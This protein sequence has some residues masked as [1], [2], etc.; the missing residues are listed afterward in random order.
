MSITSTFMR[1]V[2]V[3][4]LFATGAFL[5]GCDG[6]DGMDGAAGPAGPTG[7]TGPAGPAGPGT[8]PIEGA[9]AQAKLE[10]CGTCH[11]GAG[12]YHQAAYDGYN[13]ASDLTLA[14]EDVVSAPGAA[15]G[16]FDITMTVYVE[17]GG[18]PY[19]GGLAALPQKRF[20]IQGT[21]GTVF[22]GSLN[23]GLTTL[24]AGALPGQYTAT[25]NANFDPL[26][27]G[28]FF[29][30]GYVA[31]EPLHT[32]GMQLYDNVANAGRVFGAIPAYDSPAN[33]E[34]CEKCHGTPYMKHGYRAAEVAGLPDFLACKACHYDGRNGG[35]QDWQYMYDMPY[36]WATDQAPTADYSYE[37]IVMN[38]VHMSHG[39]EFPYPAPLVNCAT[40]HEG[41]LDMIVAE[42]NFT[43]AVCKGCHVETGDWGENDKYEQPN[44]APSMRQLWTDAGVTFHDYAMD[45][46]VC[47]TTA[48]NVAPVLADY[49]TGYDARIYNAAGEKLADLNTVAISSVSLTGT[50]LDVR[51]TA[52]NTAIVPMLGVNF[53]GWDTNDFLV[54][55]HSRDA[56]GLRMEKTIGTANALFTEEADSVAG[57]WHVTIDLANY[58]PVGIPTIP[59]LIAAGQVKTAEI[60]IMP[61]LSI[62]GVAVALDAVTK[63]FDVGTNT[64]AA[65]TTAGA[66]D[67]AKC[68]AC[69]EQLAVTFHGGS[70]RGGS[71]VACRTCHVGTSG[72]SHLEMQSRDI[73]S[74]AHAIHAFQA[75]DTDEVDFTDPVELERYKIHVEHVFPNFTILNCEGCHKPGTF[76]VPDQSK[77]MPALLSAAYEWNVDRNIG[78]VPEYVTGPASMSC[79]GC[80]RAYPI[81]E[82]EPGELATFNAHTQQMGT[83]VENDENDEVLYGIIFKIMEIFE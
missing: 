63:S 69:H 40:C 78:A 52:N 68:N 16:T 77:T 60:A 26:A 20:Y 83:L 34:G 46:Q 70:G 13:D 23:K 76:N 11:A 57:N 66:V 81:N 1:S 48:A 30:Y 6:D 75:F 27:L 31:D 54:S 7:P 5:G 28:G 19:T 32:E 38:D 17:K 29:G 33:V 61:R 49:H 3:A 64:L 43:A 8:D 42:E 50:V 55:Q 59:E 22:P 10:S 4:S 35:H 45:C 65:A 12:D 58:A 25:A 14:I 56:N 82:D 9:I 51:F 62:D 44:R 39:L 18:V 24:A 36:A 2:L 37:A 53:Y 71:I 74:Y 47:H 41:K 67:E 79:G 73:T 15:A 72:G 21:D 80:H